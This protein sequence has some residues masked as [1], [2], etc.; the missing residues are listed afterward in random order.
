MSF[1]SK[2]LKKKDN[3]SNFYV[4]TEWEKNELGRIIKTTKENINSKSNCDK[5]NSVFVEP[6]LNLLEY[7]KECCIQDSPYL[8]YF[9]KTYI[10]VD[11]LYLQTSQ[12]FNYIKNGK[13]DSNYIARNSLML[14]ETKRPGHLEEGW[15]A[16]HD[17]V[18]FNKAYFYFITD[19]LS[20]KA[21]KYNWCCSDNL[22][23]ECSIEDLCNQPLV[24]ELKY[25]NA[26]TKKNSY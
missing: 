21:Y 6:F 10:K 2:N 12:H 25:G 11:Y 1:E 5:I 17:H 13:L 20:I 14:I 3:E 18:C 4:P 15:W 9:S 22:L 19:G 26:K 16:A 23:F 24:W 8:L 7:P